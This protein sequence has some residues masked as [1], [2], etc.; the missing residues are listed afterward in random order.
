MALGMVD[1]DLGAFVERGGAG[2][3]RLGIFAAV[4]RGEAEELDAAQEAGFAVDS[5]REA[6]GGAEFLQVFGHGEL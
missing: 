3:R 5:Q 4:F 6:A 2:E 1:V